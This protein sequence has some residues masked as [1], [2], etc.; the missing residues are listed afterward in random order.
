MANFINTEQE[1]KQISNEI[2]MLYQDL[3]MDYIFVEIVK[4]FDNSY[5]ANVSINEESIRGLLEYVDYKTLKKDVKNQLEL[6]L[7]SL[8]NLKFSRYGRKQYAYFIN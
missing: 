1:R 8:K 5:Y 6:K 4:D 2:K 3:K 7:P